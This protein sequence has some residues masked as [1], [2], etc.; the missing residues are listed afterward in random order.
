MI[1]FDNE[2][3]NDAVNERYNRPNDA[4]VK[5]GHISTWDTSNVIN[6]WAMF[7]TAVKFNGDINDWNVLNVQ[8]FGYMFHNAGYKKHTQQFSNPS[9]RAFV[10]VM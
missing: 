8:N 5:Y 2:G 6:M 7:S 9:P 1:K 3:L 10:F 4:L